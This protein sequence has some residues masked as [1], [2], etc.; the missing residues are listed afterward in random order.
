MQL[1]N[2]L[3]SA[4]RLAS[5]RKQERE[6]E[7]R[8]QQ[9]VLAQRQDRE[10]RIEDLDREEERITQLMARFDSLMKE[11]RYQDA[12]LVIVE[13][14]EATEKN[15]ILADPT[16]VAASQNAHNSMMY[17]EYMRTIESANRMRARAYLD[18]EQ[19]AIPMPDDPP[20]TYPDGEVWREM[21]LRR[22]KYASVDLQDRS[23]AEKNISKALGSPVPPGGGELVFDEQPL[24]IVLDTLRDAFAETNTPINIVLDEFALDELIDT[25]N[26][27]TVTIEVRG[28][29]LRSALKLI[30]RRIDPQLTYTI[31]DEVLLITTVEES[32]NQLITKVYPVADL[33]LPIVTDLG[34]AW[35]FWEQ[36]RAV[37]Q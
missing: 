13:V 35:W 18:V 32:G 19:K 23:T 9:Q 2:K 29:S 21:T 7:L 4:I 5:I 27:P 3:R 34:A 6:K 15:P 10:Q 33:V 30:L 11:D 8:E 14:E 1:K 37:G 24:D 36:H 26:P 28:I 25:D 31:K 22:Q 12:E 17:Y 16:F 20:I